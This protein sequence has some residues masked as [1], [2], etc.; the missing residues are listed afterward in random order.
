MVELNL[1]HRFALNS[2]RHRF[3]TRAV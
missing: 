3:F 1:L 2:R